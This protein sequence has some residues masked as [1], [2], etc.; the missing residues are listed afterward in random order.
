MKSSLFG[1][2]PYIKYWKCLNEIG[3]RAYVKYD[4]KNI[5]VEV[6]HSTCCSFKGLLSIQKFATTETICIT[7]V[8]M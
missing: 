2:V 4:M 7:D 3:V 8:R 6:L 5:I 1:D